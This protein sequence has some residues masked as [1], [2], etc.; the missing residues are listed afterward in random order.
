MGHLARLH[1]IDSR[2]VAVVEG[3]LQTGISKG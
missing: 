2:H 3:D 1:L